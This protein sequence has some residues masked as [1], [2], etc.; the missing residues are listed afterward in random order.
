M[1]RKE[2]SIDARERGYCPFQ[3]RN[4]RCG[5]WCELFVDR[6]G[7]CAIR[8]ISLNAAAISWRLRG[9]E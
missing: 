9:G 6:S 7:Q 8:L 2:E 4:L 3:E 5:D 1:Y